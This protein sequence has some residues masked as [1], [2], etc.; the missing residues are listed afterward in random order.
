MYHSAAVSRNLYYTEYHSVPQCQIKISAA[1]HASSVKIPAFCNV[2]FCSSVPKLVFCNVP[3]CT[4]VPNQDFSTCHAPAVFRNQSFCNV[5]FYSSVPK[6]DFCNV[7]SY[8]S[9]QNETVPISRCVPKTRFFCYTCH[10]PDSCTK[11]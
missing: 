2:P 1:C 6:R 4:S 7:L 10:V 8:S 11:F 5:L 9:V 3:F